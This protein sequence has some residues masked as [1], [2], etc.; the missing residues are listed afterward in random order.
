MV[1]CPDRSRFCVFLRWSRSL[2]ISLSGG[3]NV[4]QGL[5]GPLPDNGQRLSGDD[6]DRPRPTVLPRVCHVIVVDD[7]SSVEDR[8]VMMSSHPEFT[9]VFKAESDGTGAIYS[10]LV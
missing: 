6:D 3:G 7:G 5:L 8:R 10:N 9:Y 1:A 4:Y 2:P